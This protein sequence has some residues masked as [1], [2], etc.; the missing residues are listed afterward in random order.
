MPRKPPQ[1]PSEALRSAVLARY[2]LEPHEIVLLDAAARTL[3][4]VGD[5]QSVVDRDGPVTA[6]G[7]VTPA[8]VE[9]RMQRLTLGRLLAAMRIPVVDDDRAHLPR[10]AVRGFYG[11]RSAS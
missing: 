1:R 4:L 9:I 8:A 5:L 10:R 3:D 11:P 7:K 2:D 6:D